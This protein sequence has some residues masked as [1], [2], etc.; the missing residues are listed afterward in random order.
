[1][2]SIKE[3]SSQNDCLG[4]RHK[5]MEQTIKNTCSLVK[6]VDWC[7][8]VYGRVLIPP[9]RHLLFFCKS[10][11]TVCIV[12]HQNYSSLIFYRRSRLLVAWAMVCF[13]INWMTFYL[14]H[15]CIKS[16]KSSSIVSAKI[17]SKGPIRTKTGHLRVFTGDSFED[18]TT[19]KAYVSS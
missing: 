19:Y 9:M 2:S 5:N 14:L 16:S 1:M 8:P 12:S 3:V 17:V 13:L 7:K 10:Y 11:T 6:V 18:C 4:I 15:Y